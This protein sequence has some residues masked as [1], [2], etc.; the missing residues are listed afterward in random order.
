MLCRFPLRVEWLKQNIPSL[1]N[2]IKNYECKD[3]DIYLKE[4]GGKKLVLYSLLLTLILLHQCM[5]THF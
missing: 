4:I 3:L 1:V 5:D 2:Q